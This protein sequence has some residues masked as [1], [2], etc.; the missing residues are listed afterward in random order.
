MEEGELKVKY[1]RCATTKACLERV[2]RDVQ[3]QKTKD[4][5]EKKKAA[6]C[7]RFSWT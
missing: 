6:K 7:Q 4:N 2:I 1:A 3:N 5:E